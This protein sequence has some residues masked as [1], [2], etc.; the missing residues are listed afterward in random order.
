ML[1]ACGA[2]VAPLHHFVQLSLGGAGAGAPWPRCVEH[3]VSSEEWCWVSL[4]CSLCQP[5][6]THYRSLI[7]HRPQELRRSGFD[8]AQIDA[9]RAATQ[10]QLDQLRAAAEAGRRKEQ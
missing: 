2:A 8:Q 6:V 5:S 7:L 10:A 9:S 3:L 4:A 1:S